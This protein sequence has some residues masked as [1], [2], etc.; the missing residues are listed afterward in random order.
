[1]ISNERD[2]KENKGTNQGQ[3]KIRKSGAGAATGCV[4]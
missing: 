2:L 3:G 4:L 1:M